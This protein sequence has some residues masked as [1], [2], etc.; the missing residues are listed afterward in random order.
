MVFQNALDSSIN[1]IACYYDS[2]ANY[3]NYPWKASELND[4]F[5]ICKDRNFINDKNCIIDPTHVAVMLNCNL[6][7]QG[8]YYCDFKPDSDKH[9][10]IGCWKMTKDADDAH[11][12]VMDTSGIYTR[13]HV[14]FDPW[15]G[16][17]K[18]VREGLCTSLRV[19]LK[20]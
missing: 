5:F 11:F 14:I 15:E 13:E 17:S 12:V 9:Y 6:A 4:I 7:F 2:I 10:I 16:G 19:F 18:T 20:V 8:K 3:R 1:H